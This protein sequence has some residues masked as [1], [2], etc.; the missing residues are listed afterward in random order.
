[1]NADEEESSEEDDDDK[2]NLRGEESSQEDVIA[3][4]L[5]Q[6]ANVWTM[7]EHIFLIA[8]VQCALRDADAFLFIHD[9]L[10]AKWLRM[11][12]AF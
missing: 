3:T 8:L 1:M 9:G 7:L 12:I 5:Q 6:S 10:S 2:T 11:T 4:D